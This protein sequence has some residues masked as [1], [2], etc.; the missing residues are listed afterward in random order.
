MSGGRDGEVIDRRP[1]PLAG[2]V[3]DATYLSDVEIEEIT[4]WSDGL[5]VKG[6]LARP[7]ARGSYPGVIVARGGN[8]EFGAITPQ[9]A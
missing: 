4:Y 3:P 9:R 2:L 6:Y 5:R 1:L 8:R 7:K